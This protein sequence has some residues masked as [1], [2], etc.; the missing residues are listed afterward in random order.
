M[1]PLTGQLA[2]PS[3]DQVFLSRLK[4]NVVLADGGMGSLLHERVDRPVGAFECLNLSEK[5]IVQKAH[6]DYLLAERVSH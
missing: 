2:T 5:D 6:L 3:A 4:E 1:T